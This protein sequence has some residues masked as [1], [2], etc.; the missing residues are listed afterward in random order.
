AMDRQRAAAAGGRVVEPGHGV[1]EA[2]TEANS[3]GGSSTVRR[4]RTSSTAKPPSTTTPP[5]MPRARG[6]VLE[7]RTSPAAA[8]R[9]ESTVDRTD[10]GEMVIVALKITVGGTVAL[11]TR[12]S[13]C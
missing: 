10:A 4:L 13:S 5:P 11:V 3:V 12:I 6:A 8:V 1:R 2:L 7:S 9:S